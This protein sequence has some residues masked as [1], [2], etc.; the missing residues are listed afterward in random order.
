[1][2][3]M[4]SAVREGSHCSEDS[5]TCTW[6]V[7]G[8]DAVRDR[9]WSV[10]GFRS[11]GNGCGKEDCHPGEQGKDPSEGS[12]LA[13]GCME[14]VLPAPTGTREESGS[15]VR[16]SRG[17][18]RNS[19]PGGK[20][21]DYE[22]GVCSAAFR[23]VRPRQPRDEGRLAFQRETERIFQIHFM[24]AAMST[25]DHYAR[26]G[27]HRRCTPEQIREAYRKMTRVFHPDVN[28][29]SAEAVEQMTGINLA[30]EILGIRHVGAPTTVT[31]R[32][33]PADVR[34]EPAGPGKGDSAG[35]G[36]FAEHRGSCSRAPPRDVS[37]RDPG[38]PDGPETYRLVVPRDG[39]GDEVSDSARVRWG[40]AC[41]C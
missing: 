36:G 26:L 39:A 41:W 4:T 29:D 30:Y 28:P 10:R 23:P 17:A 27:L 19:L 22:R 5:R 8:L 12:G 16:S 40:E 13:Q 20:S 33:G 32:N 6:L 37:V 24:S 38:N 9:V 35:S 34:A 21:L 1:M 14:K 18:V 25:P 11:V 7:S 15:G 31:W 3:Q 2:S